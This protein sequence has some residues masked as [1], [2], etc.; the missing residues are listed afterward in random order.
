[1]RMIASASV[2]RH[3]TT[4]NRTASKERVTRIEKQQAAKWR[5]TM[6]SS[7]SRSACVS[8]RIAHDAQK[9]LVA[10][11]GWFAGSGIGMTPVTRCWI[12]AMRT[13]YVLETW[14]I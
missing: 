7:R 1:M 12:I 13:Q 10:R 11:C 6:H 9:H 4:T 3:A 2:A 14:A 5:H 8:Y